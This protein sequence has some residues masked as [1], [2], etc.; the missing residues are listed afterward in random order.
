MIFTVL[1]VIVMLY[2]SKVLAKKRKEEIEA[3]VARHQFKLY[4]QQE[5]GCGFQFGGSFRSQY[6][7][8]SV[9]AGELATQFKD[10]KP[11][12]VGHSRLISNAIIGEVPFGTFYSFDYNYTVGSG[13]NS[14]RYSYGIAAF[15]VPF[16]FKCLNMRPEGFGDKILGTL[17]FEDI[18]FESDE[19][20][21]EYHID[22]EVEKFAFDIIHP[23]M[24]CYLMA[25]PKL[26]WQIAGPYIVLIQPSFWKPDA[27]E[28]LIPTVGKF[29]D[30]IPDYVRQDIGFAPTWTSAL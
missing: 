4:P 13:K 27:L 21:R 18:E 11:F 5:S 17:G 9:I 10:F 16:A 2:I 3:F 28:E 14:H 7:G 6:V 20:N 23:E 8:G 12:G 1:F 26:N 29:I 25:L 22:C 30:L 15:R 24:M 19:F